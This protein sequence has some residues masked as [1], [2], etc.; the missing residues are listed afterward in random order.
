MFLRVSILFALTAFVTPATACAVTADGYSSLREGDSY[1]SAVSK[2]GCDGEEISRSSV[3]GY[4]TVMYM[5][6]GSGLGAN[7]NAMFQ[8][9]RLVSKSQFGLTR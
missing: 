6:N 4:T 3:A 8:N 2:L 1:R 9:D 7:M 5:W